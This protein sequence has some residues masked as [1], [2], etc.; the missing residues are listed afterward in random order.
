MDRHHWDE[1]YAEHGL[2]WRAGP[3][4]FVAAELGDLQAGRAVDLGAGEGRNALWLAERG[5]RVT[6]VDFSLVA[7]EKGRQLA[8]DLPVSWVCADATT[9]VSS[10]PVDLVVLAY[11]QLPA[12]DL[13]ADLDGFDLEVLRADRVARRVAAP[14]GDEPHRG[15]HDRTAWDALLRVTRR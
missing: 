4:E 3:N 12:E 7:L 10:V 5:W 13:P 8:G 14:E 1:R 6:A 15:Q 2:V 11:L 9:W